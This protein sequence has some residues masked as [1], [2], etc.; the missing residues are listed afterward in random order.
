MDRD[1]L[2][3]QAPQSPSPAPKEQASEQAR[4]SQQSAAADIA[5]TQ[6]KNIYDKN[7]GNPHVASTESTSTSPYDRTHSPHTEPSQDA[8][9]QYHSAWQNYYQQYYAGYYAHHL[10]QKQSKQSTYFGTENTLTEAEQLTK[11]QALFELR[12]TLLTKV[13]TSATTV[14]KS[15]HFVPILSGLVVILLFLFLQY[16]RLI[17]SEVA[18]Y[19]SPGSINPQNI[20]LDPSKNIQ[21]S[22]EPRLIIPKLNIDAPVIYGVG[23]DH[24]SQMNA[25][26]KGVA[27]FAIPGANSVPG[28]LGNTVLSGHSSNDLLDSGD[29]KFIFVRLD[30][31]AVGDNIYVHYKSTRYT[32][33]VTRK[34]VVKPT[35]VDKLIYP[36][37]KPVL[38]LI[39]CT[40]IG[41]A[42]N[43]LLV[44]ADQTS[45]D[46]TTASTAPGND[47]TDIESP[48]PGNSPTLWERI[49]G[50]SSN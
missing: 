41:T 34:E 14:R 15:R 43:R 7:P 31:L 8:W 42:I 33:T 32:Y 2:S 16:N 3:P 19:I 37:T 45:P 46:P 28:Q 38:T 23:N 22:D 27:H 50:S 1:S 44:V 40:P 29:Y 9:K 21:V 5:R 26:Q 18:A 49:F 39:T 17:F 13:R 48:I 10:K 11:D 30:S 4:I 6:I 12:Q 20:V 47:S 25:M 36:A 35:Q 24:D